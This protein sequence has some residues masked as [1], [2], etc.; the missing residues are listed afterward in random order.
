[1]LWEILCYYCL[2][3]DYLIYFFVFV[4]ILFSSNAGQDS[5]FKVCI[6][7]CYTFNGLVPVQCSVEFYLAFNLILTCMYC[8]SREVCFV[9]CISIEFY[10]MKKFN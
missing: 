6:C 9:Q 10:H 5:L 8:Q 4:F 1:M 7:F 2:S 3:S